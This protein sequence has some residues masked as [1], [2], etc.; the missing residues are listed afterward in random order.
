MKIIIKYAEDDVIPFA[1][2]TGQ[3]LVSS[4]K[5]KIETA[6]KSIMLIPKEKQRLVF[7]GHEMQDDLTLSK[8][9]V[10]E[11]AEIDLLLRPEGPRAPGSG[12][13]VNFQIIKGGG[14]RFHLEDVHEDDTARTLKERVRGHQGYA[15]IPLNKIVLFHGGSALDDDL[16]LS[17]SSVKANS[18]IKV[19]LNL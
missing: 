12:F 14:G 2:V 10:L 18:D 3:D 11:G 7:N 13:R 4:V 5:E 17:Y 6:T 19:A 1:G 16:V 9:L 15:D 8:Y